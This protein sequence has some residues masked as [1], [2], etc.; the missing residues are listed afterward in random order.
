MG[1]TKGAAAAF[2]FDCFGIWELDPE[3]GDGLKVE[4][5]LEWEG[6]NLASFF[7]SYINRKRSKSLR[8]SSLLAFPELAGRSF[9]VFLSAAAEISLF[10][11]HFESRQGRS[12]KREE[13]EREMMR[14]FLLARG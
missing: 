5:E 13:R 12:R 8:P 10:I 4:R 14:R 3:S 9:K 1:K 2:S 6:T 11:S 7:I